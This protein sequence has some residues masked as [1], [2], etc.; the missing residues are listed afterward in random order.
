L[1]ALPP[2][3]LA[4]VD[5]LKSRLRAEGHDVYDF[6]LG[7]PDG[8]SPAAAIDRLV[9]EAR[10]PGSQRYMPSK[11]LPETREAICAWYRRRYGQVFDPES[12]AV[13]TIGSKEGIAHLLLA[14]VSPGDCVLAPDPCYPIHRFGVVIAGGE[15]VGVACG[16]DADHFAEIEKALAGAPRPPVGLIVNFPHNPTSAT[17]DLAYYEKVVALARRQKLWVISDL[18]YADLA[19]DPAFPTRSIF[20][21]PGAREVAV[22]FF[23]VSKSY[24][25]PGWRV[26]FCV[27]NAD[28]VGHLTTIKGYL[29]YGIFAPAQ[30]GAATA[31]N[32]CDE[33]VGVNRE[34]YRQRADLLVKGLAAAGWGVPMPKAS[35]FVWAQLP[36]PYRSQGAVA[37]A[38]ALLQDARVAVSPGVGFGPGG[39]GFVRFSLVESD[40]RVGAACAAIG[41]FL[42]QGPKSV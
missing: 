13:V 7:N 26:G 29:D 17:V 40:D 21:V 11:G 2:Y 32:T 15:P 28:L 36:A 23:T 14:L 4:K 41:Q 6:G 35:M 42:R 19:F 18:A 27:G 20:E 33:D 37:F 38:S 12:E 30:L 31:L 1:A 25:M 9:T 24:S 10:R 3:I 39:E 8:P 34:R 5:E 22:E 16:P